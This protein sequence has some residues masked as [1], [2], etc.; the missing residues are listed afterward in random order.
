VDI[1]IDTSV[2]VGALDP[3]D[4]WHQQAA[5]L[6]QTIA[7]QRHSSI[8]LDC[9]VA[10]ALSTTLR[11]SQERRLQV[12]VATVFQKLQTVV[13]YTAITWI[14][15]Q[16]PDLYGEILDLMQSSGGALNFNDALIALVCR[17]Q[18]VPAI[19]SF[20]ADFDQIPGLRRL[21]HPT[22]LTHP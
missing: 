9:V 3:A 16:V 7:Q 10:E 19:A 6:L 13:P 8:Y 2:L 14:F 22:D 17:E 4:T 11:R 5:A 20:D 1:V 12:P 15:P 18:Q 21:S